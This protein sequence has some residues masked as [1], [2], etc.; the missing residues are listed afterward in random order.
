MRVGWTRG[1]FL[2]LIST[3]YVVLRALA[4]EHMPGEAAISELLQCRMSN[5]AQRFELLDDLIGQ[6]M[7]IH[8]IHQSHQ[9]EG[10]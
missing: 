2:E 1:P 3:I 7:L 8:E 6:S 4:N 10:C 5:V 9:L